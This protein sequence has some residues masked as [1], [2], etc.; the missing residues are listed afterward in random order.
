MKQACPMCNCILYKR[1][2]GKV[3][4][5]WKCKL[6]HKLGNGWVF[7]ERNKKNPEMFFAAK[8][9]YDITRYGNTKKWLKLKSEM[10]YEKGRCEICKSNQSLCVHHIL[11]RS[12]NPELALDNENLMLLCK[13]CHI[14]IHSKDK[15]KFGKKRQL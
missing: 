7:L 10:I 6:Y 15:H 13:E 4:K 9:D 1:H 8:Y 11:P 14:E 3:C 12:S 2:E 5:N